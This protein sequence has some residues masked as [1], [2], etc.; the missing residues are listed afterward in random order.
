MTH[1]N[2]DAILVAKRE[3][4]IERT[5]TSVEDQTV[6]PHRIIVIATDMKDPG[7]P[8]VEWYEDHLAAGPSRPRNIGAA[9]ADCP[10]VACFDGDVE[11]PQDYMETALQRIR[12]LKADLIGGENRCRTGIL[13]RFNYRLIGLFSRIMGILWADSIIG[14]NFVGWRQDLLRIPFDET[15]AMME[16]ADLSRKFRARSRTVR[17]Y[18]DL[19]VFT[20]PRR[21][22][23][24]GGWWPYLAMYFKAYLEYKRHGNVKNIRYF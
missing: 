4:H 10:I 11:V 16:D 2:Y 9:L 18:R 14:N 22:R 12:S 20:R 5:I 24:A 6:P 3:R 23:C 17:F 15:M 13:D 1:G 19:Y 21:I 7:F 8:M